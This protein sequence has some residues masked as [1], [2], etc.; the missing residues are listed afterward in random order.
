M[1]KLIK[2]VVLTAAVALLTSCTT[3]EKFSRVRNGMTPDEVQRIL[4]NPDEALTS[5]EGND[6]YKWVDRYVS[7][8]GLDSADYYVVI[9]KRTNTVGKY[10]RLNFQRNQRRGVSYQPI[11]T[12]APTSAPAPAPLN[13]TST[14]YGTQTVTTCN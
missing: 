2:Y 13:C 11:Y 12:P 3:G 5:R 6:V 10:G 9:D 14:N 8:W 1:I 4:G 7:G